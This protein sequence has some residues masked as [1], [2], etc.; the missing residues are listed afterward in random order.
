VTYD[1]A[2]LEAFVRPDSLD[3]FNNENSSG[4]SENYLTRFRLSIRLAG[5]REELRQ[6]PLEQA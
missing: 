1:R 4:I 5:E 2:T 6:G 3:G